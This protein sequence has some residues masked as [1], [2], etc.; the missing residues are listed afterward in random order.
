[1][2][3]EHSEAVANVLMECGAPGLQAE[4]HDGVTTLTAYF[5]NDPPLDTLRRFCADTGYASDSASPIR[6]RHIP[7]ED[8]AKNW[9]AHFQPQLVGQRLWICPPWDAAAPHGRIS[10]VIDPGMA[11]GTGQHATT[12]G[13]LGLLERALTERPVARALDVGTGSGVLAIALAK[14]GVPEVWAVDTDPT[15]CAIAATNVR[16]NS[17]EVFV[18]I[19]GNLDEAAGEFGLVTA[20]LFANLLERMAADLS[21]R[22]TRGGVLI[23]SGFLT[24]DEQR[25]RRAYE[26]HGLQLDSRLEEQSW[27]TLTLQRPLPPP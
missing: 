10:V 9:K 11:F 26:A 6:V 24:D 25:V 19:G 4:E 20:N 8:W 3:T 12:R 23:C 16:S 13:C 1:M 22:L 2:A 15:A 5:A 17:V 14:L 7:H 27:V 21:A 18:R